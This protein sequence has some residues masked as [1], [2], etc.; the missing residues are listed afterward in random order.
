MSV[1]ALYEAKILFVNDARLNVLL[2]LYC[3]IY[4]MGIDQ[5]EANKN[6]R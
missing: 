3:F 6:Q 5:L 2:D 1:V 4:L